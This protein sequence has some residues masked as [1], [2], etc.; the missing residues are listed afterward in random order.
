MPGSVIIK[1]EGKEQVTQRQSGLMVVEAADRSATTI[2]EVISVGDV[3]DDIKVGTKLIFP[4]STGLMIAKNIFYLKYEDI[5][6][7]VS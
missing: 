4:T 3:R 1:T 6:A 7:T 2:A 5:C